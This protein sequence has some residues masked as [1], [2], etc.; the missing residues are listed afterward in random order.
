MVKPMRNGGANTL[1]SICKRPSVFNKSESSRDGIRTT[2]TQK[3][4]V[5][6]KAPEHTTRRRRYITRAA[7]FDAITYNSDSIQGCGSV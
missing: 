7:Y 6:P 3:R 2:S 4:R 5:S 1:I